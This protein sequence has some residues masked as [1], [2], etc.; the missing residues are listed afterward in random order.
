MLLDLARSVDFVVE[1]VFQR[2]LLPGRRNRVE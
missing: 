2:R 1:S